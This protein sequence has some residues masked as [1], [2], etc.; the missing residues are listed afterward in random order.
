MYKQI[1]RFFEEEKIRDRFEI[2][3]IEIPKG[4]LPPARFRSGR[5]LI[6]KD[7][8]VQM[9][10]D[11]RRQTSNRK[12]IAYVRGA[13]LEVVRLANVESVL[14]EEEL[15]AL[16]KKGIR[17]MKIGLRMDEAFTIFK[18]R[19]VEFSKSENKQLTLF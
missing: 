4:N 16:K 1:V 9:A 17:W 13:Y 3:F 12:A 6:T 7:Q 2:V 5:N 18:K 10:D 8:I 14:R 19:I 15:K 11:V